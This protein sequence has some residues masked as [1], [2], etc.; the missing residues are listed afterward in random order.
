MGNAHPERLRNILR[1]TENDPNFARANFRRFA[2]GTYLEYAYL[3]QPARIAQEY[4]TVRGKLVNYQQ[5]NGNDVFTGFKAA[6]I[7]FIAWKGGEILGS[8]KIWG[9]HLPADVT[10]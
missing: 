6:S 3:L 2:V 4:A 8:R 1:S 7:C 10:K 5:L 9:Y